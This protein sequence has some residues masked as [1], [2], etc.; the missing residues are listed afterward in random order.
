MSQ[1]VGPN[2]RAVSPQALPSGRTTLEVSMLA[3]ETRARATRDRR[4]LADATRFTSDVSASEGGAQASAKKEVRAIRS[5]VVSL[6][7]FPGSLT[8]CTTPLRERCHRSDGALRRRITRSGQ[9]GRSGERSVDITSRRRKSRVR[10]L[11]VRWVGATYTSDGEIQ[12]SVSFY[13]GFNGG[14]CPDDR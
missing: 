8:T 3:A 12:L 2:A 6:R 7:G 13:I 14:C 1:R 4:P 9:G 11:T 5:E 10:P